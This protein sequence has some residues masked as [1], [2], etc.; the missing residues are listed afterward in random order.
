VTFCHII[1]NPTT[2][3]ADLCLLADFVAT[4]QSFSHMS[5][6]IDKLY[7][8]CHIFQRVAA[9]Y[10][11]AKVQE[12]N[13]SHPQWD[14][15]MAPTAAAAP[16]QPSISDMDGHLSAMGFAPPAALNDGG[17]AGSSTENAEFDANYLQELTLWRRR[18]YSISTYHLKQGSTISINPSLSTAFS[19]NL[20]EI[21]GRDN[22]GASYLKTETNKKSKKSITPL[23]SP[24]CRHSIQWGVQHGMQRSPR[25]RLVSFCLVAILDTTVF[26]PCTV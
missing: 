10:V 11:K 17:L 13:G 15:L 1:A 21:A 20:F 18:Q 19:V 12:A 3:N 25:W 6:G 14:G 22:S 8:L 5:D 7:R 26:F 4:L 24:T 16:M 9:L 2:S 23:R